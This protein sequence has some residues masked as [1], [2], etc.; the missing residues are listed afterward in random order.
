MIANLRSDTF[1]LPTAGML[2]AMMTAEVGDDVFGEDPTINKLEDKCATMFGMEAS[3]FCPSGTMANQI[4]IRI[5]TTLQDEVICDW[6]SHIFQYEGGG[7]ASNSGVSVKL[8]EGDR[9]RLSADQIIKNINPQ[10]IHKPP[11]RLVGLENT[12]N[13]GGGSYYDFEEI[14][15]I[16]TVCTSN[17]MSLHLDG[18]R[19]FNAIVE[20]EEEPQDYGEV[21]DTISVCLSK[22]LGAPVGSLLIG[23]SKLIQKAKR[24]RKVFGGGMR[25]AGFLAAAGIYALDNNIQR[26]TED[27]SRARILGDAL[28][29]LGFVEQV[30]P[31]DTNIVIYSLTSDQSVKEHLDR[32]SKMGVL[33]LPFGENDIR[34]ITH[35]DFND[36]M[37]D[38]TVKSLNSLG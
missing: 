14:R 34:M 25:Q 16:K 31:I 8:L 7:I 26:L 6:R 29:N 17:N 2:D 32:L 12:M 3:V 38:H 35:L 22:G 21:F 33:A 18:A 10:D 30:M 19:L 28:E 5:H 36:D 15:K 20:T 13:R 37:M 11:S 24:V 4:A 27:H 1:T 9:G 23:S